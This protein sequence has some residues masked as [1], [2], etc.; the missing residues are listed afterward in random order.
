[1]YGDDNR[2]LQILVNFLSNS[3]KFSSPEKNIDV[4]LALNETQVSESGFATV[5]GD[6]INDSDEMFAR[7][8]II[9]R[10]YGVGMTETQISKLF[11]NFSKLSEHE[12]MNRSGVGLG[13]S[14]CHTLISQMGG[15]VKVESEINVGTTFTIAMAA[16]IQVS[17]ICKK[18]SSNSEQSGNDSISSDEMSELE[19]LCENKPHILIANDN[20][21]CREV[22]NLRLNVYFTVDIVI[23]GLEAFKKVVSH[24]FNHYK[25]ILLD[26]NMPIMDGV[27]ALQK[28]NAFFDE[29]RIKK[30]TLACMPDRG[31]KRLSSL[32]DQKFPNLYALTGDVNEQNRERLM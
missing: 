16:K 20:G 23:N 29:V 26:I 18:L 2:Y 21:Y 11:V 30:K 4:I 10:D 19:E 31:L 28:I 17:K 5:L 12:G 3:V 25:V 13:L 8:D 24:E 1:M 7:F 27:E 14:I 22:A 6:K 15:S 32:S 9:I